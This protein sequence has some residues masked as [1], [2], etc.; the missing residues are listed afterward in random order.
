MRNAEIY[1]AHS[2]REHGVGDGSKYSG[3]PGMRIPQDKR[4]VKGQADAA[5]NGQPVGDF[6][7]A[8]LAHNHDDIEGYEEPGELFAGQCQAEEYG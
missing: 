7:Q 8:I 2:H 5:C 3:D 1:D 6:L 4:Q